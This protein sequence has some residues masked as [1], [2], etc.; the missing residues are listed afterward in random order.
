[1]EL[2]MR[3]NLFSSR[4]LMLQAL[5]VNDNSPAFYLAYLQ[6]EVR[7]LHKLMHRRK[8]L[9]G[10][11]SAKDGDGGLDFIDH[12]DDDDD[13]QEGKKLAGELGQGQDGE[14]AGDEAK[15]VRIVVNNLVNKFG[16]DAK[17]L[18][19]AKSILKNSPHIDPETLEIISSALGK[20]KADQPL[21]Y[22]K[23]I[24]EHLD[25]DHDE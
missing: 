6:F 1:M 20:I 18:K 25:E 23:Q 24:V 22:L 9:N 16:S 14:D 8:I 11:E 17:L 2:D 15:I 21:D 19:Q 7:F 5:R 4:N 3:G 10:G 12:D 13:I